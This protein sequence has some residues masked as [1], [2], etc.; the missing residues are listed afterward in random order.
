VGSLPRGESAGKQPAAIV[1]ENKDAASPIR[2]ILSDF[3]EV[4]SFKRFESGGK[5]GA[6][7]REQGSDGSHWRR[8]RAVEGHEK[9][10]L[11]VR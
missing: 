4:A 8:L 9:R 2:G 7:H 11:P 6:I 10:E 1:G 3:N 5:R